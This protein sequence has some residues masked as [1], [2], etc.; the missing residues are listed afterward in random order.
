VKK[1]RAVSAEYRSNES[2]VRSV[3][4][5]GVAAY[6]VEAKAFESMQRRL[7]LLEGLARGEAAIAEGKAI[8]HSRARKRM[9]RWL[10]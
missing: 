3:E 6:V 1:R 9:A 10:K 7:R 2:P 4:E 5:N 8:K